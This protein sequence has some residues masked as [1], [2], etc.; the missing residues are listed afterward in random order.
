MGIATTY[1]KTLGMA[2]SIAG[3][4]TELA[5]WLNVPEGAVVDWLQGKS[6]V[7]PEVFLRAVD[8]VLAR[9]K[10]EVERTRAMTELIRR[11]PR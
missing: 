2:C 6:P 4:E 7:P 10:V 11:R 8:I 1:Q 9:T 5:R 3:D